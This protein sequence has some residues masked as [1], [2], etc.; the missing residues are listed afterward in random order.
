MNTEQ[1]QKVVS[2]ALPLPFVHGLLALSHLL[3]ESV[4]VALQRAVLPEALRAP[5]PEPTPITEPAMAA[6]KRAAPSPLGAKRAAEILGQRI[7]GNSLSN[8]FGKCVDEIDALDPA[9][10]HRLALKKTHAR[11]YVA[12]LPEMIHIKSPHLETLQ[13][14]SGWW[15]SQN[16][17]ELQAKTAIRLLTEAAELAFGKDVIFPLLN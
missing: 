2:L 5:E 12:R 4:V 14:Q 15:I 6:P 16:V 7:A 10:L 8:L 3:D 11:R 9:A 1:I 17:S 13:T